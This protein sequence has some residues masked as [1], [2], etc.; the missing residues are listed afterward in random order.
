MLHHVLGISASCLTQQAGMRIRGEMIVA[1]NPFDGRAAI[2]DPTTGD[3]LR[4]L[5]RERFELR[6][7]PAFLRH[8]NSQQ[9][10]ALVLSRL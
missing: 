8:D 3:V 5:R 10:R 2:V 1:C 6:S 4:A 7:N 9:G